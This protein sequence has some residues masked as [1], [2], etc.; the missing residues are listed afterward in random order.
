MVRANQKLSFKYFGLFRV[1]DRF[2][3][4]ATSSIHPVIQASQ[5]RRSGGVSI[6]F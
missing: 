1:L 5:L 2:G 4:V 3:S 6:T